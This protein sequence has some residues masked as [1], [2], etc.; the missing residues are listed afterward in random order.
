MRK[1]YVIDTN[2]L[3]EDENAIKNLRNGDENDI[4]IPIAV[5]YELDK[6]KKEK[7]RLVKSALLQL[8]EFADIIKFTDTELNVE[9]HVDTDILDSIIGSTVLDENA[10][11]VS[12]DRLMRFI[13]N[14]VY[15]IKSEEYIRSKPSSVVAEEITGIHGEEVPEVP[16]YYYSEGKLRYYNNE[17]VPN[18]KVWGVTPKTE[19]QKAL[20]ASILNPGLDIIS[21]SSGAGYG[22]T[23]LALACSLYL[24]F[25]Q[26]KYKKIKICRPLVDSSEKIGF[27]PGDVNEKIQQYFYPV[28]DLLNELTEERAVSKLYKEDGSFNARKLELVPLNFLRGANFKNCILII[29]EVQNISR[30]ELRTILTR[31]GKNCKVILLGDVNQVDH[32]RLNKV[33]NGLNWLVDKLYGY[34]NYIHIALTGKNMRGKICETILSA[35]L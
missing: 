2:V 25:E 26:K 33:N 34:D 29:D 10:I 35:G 28:I 12:N 30:T 21:C 3:L 13:A 9:E 15:D 31:C 20:I 24:T 16:G 7:P 17:V 18:Y 6:L 5:L 11:L 1:T 22:K 27:L 32:P 19:A 4:I 14:S 23:F 8:E